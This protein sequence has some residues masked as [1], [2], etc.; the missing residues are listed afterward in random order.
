M[1]VF[2]LASPWTKGEEQN[3][4]LRSVVRRRRQADTCHSIFTRGLKII[5]KVATEKAR[6]IP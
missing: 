1:A 4:R 6:L 2:P 3:S 5:N